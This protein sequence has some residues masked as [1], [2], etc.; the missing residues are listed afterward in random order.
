MKMEIM[1][2]GRKELFLGL[3]GLAEAFAI[4]IVSILL[5]KK[6]QPFEVAFLSL[7]VSTLAM[8][9]GVS[10]ICSFLNKKEFTIY[11]FSIDSISDFHTFKENYKIE[12]ISDE[13]VLCIKKEDEDK[14]ERYKQFNHMSLYRFTP[15]FFGS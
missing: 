6:G 3:L 2:G 15:L 8:L 12:D 7:F 4:A 10:G 13:A 1:S 14:C 5:L 9:Q 11:Y